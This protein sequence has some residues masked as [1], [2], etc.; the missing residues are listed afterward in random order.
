MD[1]QKD[2]KTAGNKPEL[3]TVLEKYVR[4]VKDVEGTD[5]ISIQDS[6]RHMSYVKFTKKAW[7][8][9]EK[10]SEKVNNPNAT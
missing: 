7:E 6:R 10:I 9:L 3:Y 5:Y 4:Y 8:I 2:D 1:K